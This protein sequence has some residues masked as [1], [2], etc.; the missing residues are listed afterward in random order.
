[1]GEI[2]YGNTWGKQFVAEP[3]GLDYFRTTSFL[4]SCCTKKS[5]ADIFLRSEKYLPRLG[6]V[7]YEMINN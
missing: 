7:R 6:W 3:I 4:A 5:E 1:M 2:L